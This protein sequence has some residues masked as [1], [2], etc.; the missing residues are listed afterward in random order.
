[1]HEIWRE[2]ITRR[3]A[4]TS[5]I[6]TAGLMGLTG[7]AW[8]D[9][10]PGAASSPAHEK[11]TA[12]RWLVVGAHPDDEAKATALLLKERAPEDRVTLLI[13]RLC[14]EGKLF[15][16]DTWTREEAIAVRM[17]EMTQA[18][19]FLGADLRWWLAP[20]PANANIVRTPETVA[21]MLAILREIRPTRIVANWHE[22]N[23][24]DHVG[25]GQV[26]G[27]AARQWNVPGGVP[28]YWFGTPGRPQA[29]P[30]F[31]P[32]HYVDLSAP[33][34]LATV[35]WS[36]MVHRSQAAFTALKHHIEYY[37][38]HGRRFGTQ[39]ATGYLLERIGADPGPGT[40]AA[41]SQSRSKD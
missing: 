14:G 8:S 33:S 2:N 28:V 5:S 10:G 29:Q 1:M 16:R 11:R 17:R 37:H 15:D 4:L 12:Q 38:E 34:D 3:A 22:D 30:N 19:A 35:L 31:I 40:G 24:P 6:K 21:K 9:P 7:A 32:N 25:V 39:Y 26:V 20:D 41:P 27:E 18:A 13:M 36:R 23:H